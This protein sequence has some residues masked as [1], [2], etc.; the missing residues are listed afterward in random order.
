LK[1]KFLAL[2]FLFLGIQTSL[3]GS[4]D[5][6]ILMEQEK[7][8]GGRIDWKGFDPASI[9][10][11]IFDGVNSYLINHPAPP[12]DFKEY[13]K[14]AGI[15]YF[16][17]RHKE[18]RA[19][20]AIEI[21]GIKTACIDIDISK[22]ANIQ[23]IAALLLHEKFHCF[24]FTNPTAWGEG[25]NEFAVF[26]YPAENTKLLKLVYLEI[27]AL[28]KAY[29]SKSIEDTQKWLTLANKLR[30]E[31]HKI[32]PKSCVEFER[33][34]ELIE[35]T[36]FYIQNKVSGNDPRNELTEKMYLPDS[37]R[38]RGYIT[39]SMICSLLDK[40]DPAWKVKLNPRE[41]IYPDVLLQKSLPA[42]IQ[43]YKLDPLTEEKERLKAEKAVDD[44]LLKK[45]KLLDA[46]V[47]KPGYKIILDCGQR[48]LWPAGFD[49]M[50]I[51][52]LNQFELLHKR[53]LKLAG[54]R[55]ELEILD[56]ESITEGTKEHPLFNGVKKI[57]I[58]G[59][60]NKP[61]VI[62]EDKKINI[63]TDNISISIENAETE[64]KENVLL[65]YLK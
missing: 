65:I 34:I 38:L 37:I 36:A 11:L 8:L 58:S 19:N 40:I 2:I 41:G 54:D 61:D 30:M 62:R 64:M 44:Y 46:F 56:A 47:N 49:P 57:I 59:L 55:A 15:Y 6:N 5:L 48:P 29:D 63:K 26:E 22:P 50:N 45:I 17:G 4:I 31:K 13:D 16:Q 9:P 60:K 51:E 12:V 10:A 18:V 32:M 28:F 7:L 3:Y 27:H 53:W 35:G 39:G 23:D 52:K 14:K 20:T 42:D 25:T 21:S 1:C 43:A 33:G 24:Q